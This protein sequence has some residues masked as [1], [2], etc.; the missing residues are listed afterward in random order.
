MSAKAGPTAPQAPHDF[1][2][3]PDSIA[4]VTAVAIERTRKLEDAIGSLKPQDCTFQNVVL[5]LALD[6]AAFASETD[7]AAFMQ[8]VST[9]KL[10][11][12]AATEATMKISDFSIESS[13][14]KDIYIALQNVQQNT[15]ANSLGPESARLLERMLRD[16]RRA[17]LAL[18]DDKQ[19][20]FKDIKTQ[21]SNKCI[22]FRKNCD[23]ENGLILLTKE[24]LN[25]VPKDVISGYPQEQVGDTGVQYKVTHKTPDLV[26]LMRYCKNPDTRRRA[27]LSNENRSS[28][29]A[30][31]FKEI[32]EL[33]REAADV[34]GY[35]EWASFVT[36]TKM[37]K[38]SKAAIEFLDDL[39][40][41]IKPIGEKERERLIALKKDDCSEQAMPFDDTFY[42]WDY[43]YLDRLYTERTLKLDDEETKA[44][45][46]V[47]KVVPKMMELYQNLLGVQC[48]P[49]SDATTWYDEVTVW[50]VWDKKALQQN[51]ETKD[52]FCGYL[53]LDLFPRD[54]KAS[55]SLFDDMPGTVFCH[56]LKQAVAT[57]GY[58]RFH[59][60]SVVRDFVEAPSQ[61][62]ENWCYD[63]SV[64]K[65][66]SSH[67]QIGEPMPDI[68]I[69]KI[70]KSDEINQGLFNLRQLFFGKFDLT[71]HT[72]KDTIDYTKFWN[73]LRA[74][75]STASTTQRK[76][77]SS[78]HQVALT[79][80]GNATLP[81]GQASFAHLVGGY[82][83]GYYGYLY[84]QSFSA[85]MFSTVFAKN[86]LS[87][88]E[89]M[90]YR[91]EILKPGGSRDEMESLK[92]FLGRAPNNE[93]FM[94]KLMRGASHL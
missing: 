38:T 10:V 16:K 79:S 4:K 20:K 71:V 29:N 83:A 14:R 36:E 70:V 78:A 15:P 57:S 55:Q 28:E 7:P 2:Y 74:E 69:E 43:R 66:L 91:R 67:Y 82:D 17:G 52:G 92:A 19:A 48:F 93:A 24:E 56:A 37:V 84:S 88:E 22:E 90:H 5:P 77:L 46:P 27:Y 49:A 23:E 45:L 33:R 53:Y 61:M 32:I 63:P 25:G 94:K 89:G 64:L 72:S 18:P 47:T 9:N 40:K 42:A 31:L 39:Q 81:P 51:E 3:S 8:S 12:D 62:L 34:I 80:I 50:A 73:D 54:S 6:E 35:D 30:P 11:R 59:G 58:S 68:L 41:K 65:L 44:Y 87:S 76:V 86:P 13:M 26:P 85:D 75:A 21:I 1:N 60:T